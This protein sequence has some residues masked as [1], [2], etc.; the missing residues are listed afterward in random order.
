MFVKI[1]WSCR[2]GLINTIWC[3]LFGIQC[4]NGHLACSSCCTVLQKNNCCSCNKP[5]GSNRC[6]AIE[7]VLESAQVKCRY[8]TYGCKESI[9]YGDQFD[10]LGKCKHAPCW[11][12]ISD[13]KFVGTSRQLYQH[14]SSK[15]EKLAVK[16]QYNR[17]S[18]ITLNVNDKFLVL[19]EEK[20]ADVL[21]IVS[22][23]AIESAHTEI[24]I[25]CIASEVKQFHYDITARWKSGSTLRIQSFTWSSKLMSD[26]SSWYGFLVIPSLNRYLMCRKLEI[27]IWELG[28]TP[29]GRSWF[30]ILLSDEF[31]VYIFDKT[32]AMKNNNLEAFAVIVY[33]CLVY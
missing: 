20:D 10:H 23:K 15:H 28:L 19:Q 18:H 24:S 14:F 16:F 1:Y 27:C 9:S 2:R 13:C 12:P 6:R 25:Q 33:C 26:E 31:C 21:F 11:C 22:N 7:K 29:A 8:S 32:S 17:P 30:L 3:I 4:E 5:T